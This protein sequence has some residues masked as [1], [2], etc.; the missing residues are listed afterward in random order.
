ASEIEAT[1]R[2]P[3]PANQPKPLILLDGFQHGGHARESDHAERRSYP[4]P[5]AGSPPRSPR[6][7]IP[8][9]CPGGCNGGCPP[10]RCGRA[11]PSLRLGPRRQGPHGEYAQPDR[12]E[13]P[14]LLL[15]GEDRGRGLSGG[16]LP[17]VPAASVQE[18]RRLTGRRGGGATP[19]TRQVRMALPRQVLLCQ[20]L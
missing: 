6:A 7:T 4:C 10:G 8:E 5:P 1:R 14:R 20:R 18:V 9:G 16:D 19:E 11:D 17:A 3:R 15:L 13:M 12:L 2:S